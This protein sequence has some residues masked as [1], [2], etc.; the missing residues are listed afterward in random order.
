[1]TQPTLQKRE[2]GRYAVMVDGQEVGE[3][4]HAWLPSRIRRGRSQT[5]PQW[6][7]YR[8]NPDEYYGPVVGDSYGRPR[9]EFQTRREAVAVLVGAS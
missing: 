1:M 2:V 7:A 9:Y 8:R 5:S 6:C 4:R 3:V